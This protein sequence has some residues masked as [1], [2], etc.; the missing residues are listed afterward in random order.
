MVAELLLLFPQQGSS[1]DVPAMR[2]DLANGKRATN[3]A[4]VE[5][6]LSWPS[7]FGGGWQAGHRPNPAA[8]VSQ[9]Q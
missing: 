3:Q 8:A 6:A 5:L 7:D 4:R 1:D 2:R 9:P